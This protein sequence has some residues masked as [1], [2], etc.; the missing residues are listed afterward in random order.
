[1]SQKVIVWERYV[2]NTNWLFRKKIEHSLDFNFK[3]IMAYTIVFSIFSKIF[4]MIGHTPSISSIRH[5]LYEKNY[6]NRKETMVFTG[7]PKNFAWFP[8]PPSF[9]HSRPFSISQAFSLLLIFLFSLLLSLPFPHS[10]YLPL[11]NFVFQRR[12]KQIR[13]VTATSKSPP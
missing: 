7:V 6:R 12:Q 9:F 1:M 2:Q 5:L 11:F 10:P 3:P 4:I 8:L 13:Q